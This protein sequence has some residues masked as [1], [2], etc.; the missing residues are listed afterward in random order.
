MR[1]PVGGRV[2]Q[3]FGV[4]E[5]YYGPGGHKGVDYAA[6]GTPLDW[7]GAPVYATR[8][9]IARVV[10][11]SGAYGCYVYVFGDYCDELLA[12]LADVAIVDKTRVFPGDL[13]G[14]TGYTGNCMPSDVRG[15]HLHWGIRPKPY[16]MDNG[17]RGYVDPLQT[18]P[19]PPSLPPTPP[20]LGLGLHLITEYD[21]ALPTSG[22]TTVVDPNGSLLGRLREHCGDN[23][24]LV[25]REYLSEHQQAELLR[26]G[27]NG[28]RQWLRPRIADW[29]LLNTAYSLYFHT[30]INEPSEG[31]SPQAAALFEAFVEALALAG[32][33]AAGPALGSGRPEKDE[34]RTYWSTSADLIRQTQGIWAQHCYW[35]DELDLRQVWHAHRYDLCREWLPILNDVRWGI[36]ECGRDYHSITGGGP[37][38]GRC[39]AE[40]YLDELHWYAEE[41]ARRGI[42]LANVFTGGRIWQRWKNYNVNSIAHR[43]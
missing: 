5:D 40:Q 24:V 29:Q 25:Y 6:T 15:C 26:S 20:S 9:G 2:S 1:L 10:R 39:N 38:I 23:H 33:K 17:T 30:P 27:V 13:V 7:H 36:T 11:S 31:D 4:N 32:L 28:L 21:G 14:Y 16:Q 22:M 34:L 41:T 12:H 37:W 43:I 3:R 35:S 19:I 42:N 8:P 18:P